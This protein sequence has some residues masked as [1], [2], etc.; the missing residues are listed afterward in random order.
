M[1]SMDAAALDRLADSIHHAGRQLTLVITGGGTESIGWLLRVPG[2]SRSLLEAVVPYSS[3]ALTN[4][5]GAQPEQYCSE[6]TSRVMAMA[7]FERA[8]RL[9]PESATLLAAV[10]CTASLMSDRPKR[11]A[12]RAHVA[13]QTAGLT[14]SASLE[15]V[16]GARTR[17]EEERLVA[18]LVLCAAAEGVGV[19]APWDSL[20]LVE[21]ER[22]ERRACRAPEEWQALLLGTRQTAREHDERHRSGLVVFPGAFHPRHTGHRQMAEVA[23]RL[24]GQGAQHEISIANVDKPTLDYLEMEARQAQFGGDEPVWFTRA[25]RFIDKAK[26]F[27]GAT[28][29]VGADTIERIAAL[30]YYDGDAAARDAAIGEL[31]AAGARFLVFGRTV[32]G[33]FQGL[34]DMSLP[35][36]L[37]SLCQEV[38]AEMF[39]QDISST[40]LRRRSADESDRN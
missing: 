20:E 40:E 21:Q 30:R 16:K 22:I 25:P 13:W 17:K 12:H 14:A 23:E 27:P 33:R 10:G 37:L 36:A 11:G 39:R 3:A 34:A 2:G 28:F 35:P 4:Y 7:A 26:V 8:R 38:P 32:E 29:V 31:A 24:T 15:L 1:E 9:A 5:L 6:A 19:P 18:E